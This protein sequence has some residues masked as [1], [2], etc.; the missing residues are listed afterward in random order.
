[1]LTGWAT[2]AQGPALVLFCHVQKTEPGFS[3]C[4][5]T[6]NCLVENV[7][8]RIVSDEKVLDRLKMRHSVLLE[9]EGGY[10]DDDKKPTK[11]RDLSVSL[12]QSSVSFFSLLANNVIKQ[13]FLLLTCTD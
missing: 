11:G 4:D 12:C 8:K 6:D 2:T 9:T 3:K 13:R 7:W 1:M 10:H 5:R